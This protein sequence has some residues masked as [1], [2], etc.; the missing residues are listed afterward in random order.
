MAKLSAVD[1]V[2]IQILVDNVTDSLSSVPSFVETE[3]AALGRRR[4]AAWVLGGA[5]L[6]CAAHGLSCLLTLRSGDST[7]TVLFDSGPEDRT[8]EQNVS[9]LGVDLGPVEAMVLSH[10][11]WDHAGAMLRALQLVRDRNGGR[12]VPCYMHPD[13]FR[14]R[15]VKMPDGSFRLMEDVPSEAALAAH[16]ARVVSTREAQ[17]IAGDTV[18]VSGEIP[19]RSGFEVGMPGQHR[20]TLDGEGWE[21]DELLVDERFIAFHVRGKGLV[22]LTAC[23]H[24]G[25]INVL[26][27]ARDCFPG[28]K[29]HAVLGG[30]HLSGINERIIPQTVAALRGFDL[31]VIAAG[32]CTGWRATTALANEFGDGTLVPLAVGKRL[33]F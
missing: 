4:G 8:F 30:L 23:S 17:A 7:R 2:D 6:C 10:G 29:L 27:H 25:V 12:E 16:G 31:D 26:A 3:T 15:S 9:R 33:R 11:H 20:R 24:A 22:V 5:C 21:L 1:S 18:F 28:V 13:M 32:H 19:R 14:S